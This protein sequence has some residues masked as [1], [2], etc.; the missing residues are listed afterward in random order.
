M[1]AKEFIKDK[2]VTEVAPFI[3]ALGGA[4]ARKALAGVG[5]L[6]GDALSGVGSLAG[7]AVKG[8]K[9]FNKEISPGSNTTVPP[10]TKIEPTINLD[11]PQKLNVKVGDANLT[12]DLKDPKNNLVA[13]QLKQQVK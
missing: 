10:N 4:L 3:A 6:A 7:G 11:D 2:N 5:S 8:I 1:R 12:L 13:Q 9:N